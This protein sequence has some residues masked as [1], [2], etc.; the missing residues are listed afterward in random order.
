MVLAAG[1]AQAD[2]TFSG[3]AGVALI[4][5]NGASVYNAGTAGA[6]ATS[7]SSAVDYVAP[8]ARSTRDGMFFESYYDFNIAASAESD[9]GI[10][11]SVGFDMGAGNK[12]D[13]NDDDKL[14]A[15]GNDVGDAD[16]T[17]GYAGWTLAVDQG[18]IDN[19]FDDGDGAQDVSLSG[20]VSGVSVAVTTDLEGSTNSYK[21]AGTVAGVSLTATG[22]DAASVGG[23]ASKIAASYAMDNGLTLSASVQDEDGTAEDDNTLGLSYAMGD[24][25]VGYTTIR[26]GSAGSFGDEWD[27]SVAYAAG[28][29]GASFATDETDA[30]TFIF[31]YALGG[32]AS[33]FAA[34]HDKAGT[35]DDLTAI[36]L[37]FAF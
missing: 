24:I 30:T 23:S 21:V 31:D 11:V 14:E 1:V 35:N 27:F 33:A 17:V 15:Q 34:M 5:D 7:T 3:A 13:Y 26:P 4:D 2:V 37:N 18:G 6:A 8:V 29:V 19:L 20:T 16:V 22:T 9:N 28:A 36:G 25:T 10:S 12:I 32:G